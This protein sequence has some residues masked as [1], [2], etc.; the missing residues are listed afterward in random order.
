MS[1]ESFIAQDGRVLYRDPSPDADGP[2]LAQIRTTHLSPEQVD[3]FSAWA[4]D[5]FGDDV[6]VGGSREEDGEFWMT[7]R[8]VPEE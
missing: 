6:S 8:A 1:D 4:D 7:L 3:A 2:L 5:A